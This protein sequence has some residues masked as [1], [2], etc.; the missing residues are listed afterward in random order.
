MSGN[1]ERAERPLVVA[2]VCPIVLNTLEQILTYRTANSISI[3]KPV[4]N[5]L[6][7]CLP[8]DYT[9]LQVWTDKQA[10][11]CCNYGV[12]EAIQ[13]NVSVYN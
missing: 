2:T 10:P 4:P 12:Q 8:N 11:R 13:R 3:P 7:I 1:V 5:G 9:Y 6:E